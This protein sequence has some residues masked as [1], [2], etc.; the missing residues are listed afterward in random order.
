MKEQ[1]FIIVVETEEQ[2]VWRPTRLKFHNLD[3]AFEL[4]ES[5]SK[6]NFRKNYAIYDKKQDVLYTKK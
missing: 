5:I 3:N 2:G 4:L 1:N 6:R